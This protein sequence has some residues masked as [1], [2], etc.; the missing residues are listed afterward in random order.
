MPVYFTRPNFVHSRFIWVLNTVT[1]TVDKVRRAGFDFYQYI[2]VQV[3]KRLFAFKESCH[4]TGW[5]LYSS[6]ESEKISKITKKSPRL[7]REW[8]SLVN[9]KDEFVLATGGHS[10]MPRSSVE[11][12]SVTDDIWSEAP[13]LNRKRCSHSSCALDSRVYVFGGQAL[14]KGKDWVNLNSIEWLDAARWFEGHQTQW[15]LIRPAKALIKA[16]ATS[17]F[18]A[19]SSSEL[20]IMGGYEDNG[21]L[22][23]DFIMFDTTSGNIE[24]IL[25]SEKPFSCNHS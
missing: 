21:E 7:A 9:F 15:F 3:D 23:R 18:C 20:L 13:S 5:V 14:N 8:L 11:A 22:I 25:L 16:R 17:L 2:T 6:L 19:I 4:E 12:Y 24:P 10:L 1:Y